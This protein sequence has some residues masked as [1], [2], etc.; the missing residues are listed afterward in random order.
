MELLLEKHKIGHHLATVDV[1]HNNGVV[2]NLIKVWRMMS[3]CVM[4]ELGLKPEEFRIARLV[5][6]HALL[7]TKTER[8]HGY[9]PVTVMFGL[10]PSTASQVVLVGNE[11]KEMSFTDLE[12]E[13]A[14]LVPQAQEF[15]ADI[16]EGS[17]G[18]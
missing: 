18:E 15:L 6:K 8:L 10:P 13:L 7:H 2:E 3:R 9:A 1:H 11:L 5:V 4:A 14:Q 17:S 16:H 12:G